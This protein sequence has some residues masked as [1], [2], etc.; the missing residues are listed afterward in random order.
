MTHF[1]NLRTVSK[2]LRDGVPLQ[3]IADQFGW[4]VRRLDMFIYRAGIKHDTVFKKHKKKT[5]P[6]YVQENLVADPTPEEL[7]ARVAIIQRLNG[8]PPREYHVG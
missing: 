3:S 7:K 4:S 6:A 8:W 1:E 5:K 2:L